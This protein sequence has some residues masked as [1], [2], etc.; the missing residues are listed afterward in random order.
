MLT[1]LSTKPTV[2]LE[3]EEADTW[4]KKMDD[5][6]LAYVSM[7]CSKELSGGTMGD[8]DGKGTALKIVRPHDYGIIAATA[9]NIIDNLD[10]YREFISAF[11]V[12]DNLPSSVY[13]L[14]NI[15][16]RGAITSDTDSTI[17]TVKYWTEWYVGKLDFTEKSLAVGATMVYLASQLIR[18]ILAT[19][20]GNIGAAKKDITRLSM[21]NE[22][23]FP[24][25]TLTSRA[26]HYF[27][28]ISAREG[29]VY[30]KLETEIKGVALRNSNVPPAITK[31]AHDL[32]RALMDT[33][34]KER[35]ISLT[36]VLRYVAEIE[37]GIRVEVESG[38][39]RLL[40]KTSIKGAASYKDPTVSNYVHYGMWEKVFAP[41]YGNAPEPPYTAIKVSLS[42]KSPSK[43]KDWIAG[44]EDRALADRLT[45]WMVENGR[46][47]LSTLLLPEPV[48]AM[49]GIPKEL[50]PAIDIRN[51]IFQTMEGYYLILEAIG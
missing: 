29:N 13:F 42:T 35:K 11:W 16:R 30:K 8:A 46:K 4:V 9:K 39:Y 45:E 37:E 28:Y 23:Y 22:Y 41:K 6:L 27:A 3:G 21:K 38:G 19:V 33:V 49:T 47:D 10:R 15:M 34:M 24:V 14:P 1:R 5:N 26:K 36:A 7:L 43:V 12:T 20:S 32:I 48:L 40:A 2:V 31:K 44:I 18:H 25:F 50:I 17:F 51:L